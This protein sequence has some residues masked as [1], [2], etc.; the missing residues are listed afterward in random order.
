M[1]AQTPEAPAPPTPEELHTLSERFPEG[2]FPYLREAFTLSPG[3]SESDFEFGIRALARGLT[4]Q[5]PS[6]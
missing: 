5:L 1:I 4:E 3:Y 6:R 2:E